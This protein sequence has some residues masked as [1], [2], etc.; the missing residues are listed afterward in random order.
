MRAGVENIADIM[1]S[2]EY[3]YCE[4][5]HIR[6]KKINCLER[7]ASELERAVSM[8]K[9]CEQYSIISA[10]LK[11]LDLGEVKRKRKSFISKCLQNYS[12]S[13]NKSKKV[14]SIALPEK[15]EKMSTEEKKQSDQTLEPGWKVCKKCGIP[16]EMEKDFPKNPGC[17]DG[18]E[19]Q[20]KEC[21]NE[22]NKARYKRKQA[23]SDKKPENRSDTL[24]FKD[25]KD[26][27]KSETIL[28][29]H[30]DEEEGF[31]I[32][33]EKQADESWGKIEK[34]LNA[35]EIENLELLAFYY[36]TG[37][38]NGCKQTLFGRE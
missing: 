8:C 13:V 24:E 12:K 22:T 5:L 14:Q 15:E 3:F 28:P 35:H 18:Y 37:F 17:K 36:K 10:D 16:K 21:R 20:C 32:S 25:R 2:P 31:L 29:P 33:P 7:Y 27:K 23:A 34:I 1:N 9:N 4:R 6:M 26:E 19:G 11:N 38:A 30:I